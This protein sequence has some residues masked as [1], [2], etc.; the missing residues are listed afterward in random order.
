MG[1]SQLGI[2]L[3]DEEVDKITAFLGSLTGEQPEVTYP[4]LP[5]SVATTPHPRP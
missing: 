3:T 2:E 1:A 5:P 4:I